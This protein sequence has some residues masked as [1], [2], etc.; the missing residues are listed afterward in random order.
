MFLF[1]WVGHGIRTPLVPLT[2]LTLKMARLS[3]RLVE[4]KIRD[5]GG[6]LS[7]VARAFGVTRQAVHAF[8]KKDPELQQVCQD[9]R[10]TIVDIAESVLKKKILDGE[11]WAVCFFLK[12]QGKARGYVERQEVHNTGD[13]ARIQIVE[14]VVNAPDSNPSL[15]DTAGVPQE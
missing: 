4:Q 10:E 6:N 13:V 14:E 3:K 8:V 5:M 15:P 11:A 7:A 2:Q 1:G 9:E 12:C